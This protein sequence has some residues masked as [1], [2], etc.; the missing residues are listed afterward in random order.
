MTPGRAGGLVLS[1]FR[2]FGFPAGLRKR[3]LVVCMR[4]EIGYHTNHG[5]K[6]IY[7]TGNDESDPNGHARQ[8]KGDCAGFIIQGG[9]KRVRTRP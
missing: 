2:L 6:S 8:V 1:N 4:Y 3:I 5:F 9:A 7:Q